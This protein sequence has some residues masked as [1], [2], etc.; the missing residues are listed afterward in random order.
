MLELGSPRTSASMAA[1]STANVVTL[2]P[3]VVPALP[4]PTNIS[5]QVISSVDASSAPM[6]T[7]LNPAVRLIAE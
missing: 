3:P 1:A 7:E 6:S 5:M 2:M 4:P